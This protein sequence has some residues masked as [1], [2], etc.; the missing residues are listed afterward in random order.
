MNTSASSDVLWST[1]FLS[2][3]SGMQLLWCFE[4]SEVFLW[5]HFK[6]VAFNF[7]ILCFL[8]CL[9]ARMGV[10][11]LLPSSYLRCVPQLQPTACLVVFCGCAKHSRQAV[12]AV[13]WP[14]S[15]VL[16]LSSKMKLIFMTS[17]SCHCLCCTFVWNNTHSMLYWTF[18]SI[19]CAC[20]LIPLHECHCQ[21]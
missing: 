5:P 18:H 11:R 14:Y 13:T 4:N 20:L 2:L 19:S 9:A 7:F 6:M 17:M 8:I 12:C 3:V 1:F 21:H 16:H 10:T 15:L